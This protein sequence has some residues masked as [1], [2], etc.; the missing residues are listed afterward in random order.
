MG[1]AV[2]RGVVGADLCIAAAALPN[3]LGNASSF[4]DA[5][6][7]STLISLRSLLGFDAPWCSIGGEGAGERVIGDTEISFWRFMVTSWP[8]SACC[9]GAR[10]CSPEKGESVV[11]RRVVFGFADDDVAGALIARAWALGGTE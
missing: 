6:M 5:S 8:G 7:S 10:R 1:V 9:I 4:F 3:G 11:R 2:P